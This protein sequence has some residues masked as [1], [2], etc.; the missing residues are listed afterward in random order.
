MKR[1]Y[2]CF[3]LLAPLFVATG[4]NA[5]QS[6]ARIEILPLNCVFE[7]INDGS[8]N[9]SYLTPAACWRYFDPPL[10]GEPT[11]PN[12]PLYISPFLATNFGTG[13]TTDTPI[14]PSAGNLILLNDWKE[15]ETQEQRLNLQLR[16]NYVVWF[17]VKTSGSA[18]RHSITIN[19]VGADYVTLTI[20]STPMRVSLYQGQTAQYD[21]TNDGA[22]DI[23][24]HIDTISEEW[25]TIGFKQLTATT[26]SAPSPQVINPSKLPLLLVISL[27]VLAGLTVVNR[28]RLAR[29]H[30][31]RG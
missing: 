3:V 17:D 15:Y 5:E 28:H 30:P 2:F 7:V 14:I 1:L 31:K 21:V 25:V 20:A 9:I 13:P 11:T 18:E 26:L 16:R 10:P 22:A 4:V 27:G 12:I 8:N 29:L 24:I 19:E 23:E 6:R